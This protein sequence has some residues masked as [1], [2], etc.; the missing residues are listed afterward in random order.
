MTHQFLID[1]KDGFTQ[2]VIEHVQVV[3]WK[4][5]TISNSFSLKTNFCRGYA[6]F[7]W[8][9]AICDVL[10]LTWKP[11][12]QCSSLLLVCVLDEHYPNLVIVSSNFPWPDAILLE[13][14]VKLWQKSNWIGTRNSMFWIV[15]SHSPGTR[16]PLGINCFLLW[17]RKRRLHVCILSSATALKIISKEIWKLRVPTPQPKGA[18]S[19]PPKMFWLVKRDV[20]RYTILL[21]MEETKNQ[22]SGPLDTN[23]VRTIVQFFVVSDCWVW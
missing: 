16:Y 5:Q 21:G 17:G 15:T 14:V 8:N 23:K 12:I 19:E 4:E 6:K 18:P 2:S 11:S 3:V 10:R 9:G 7:Q 20:V 22:N 13:R 1:G